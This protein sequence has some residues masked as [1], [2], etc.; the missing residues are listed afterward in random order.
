MSNSTFDFNVFI[1][2]SKDVLTNPKA[3]FSTMKTTGVLLNL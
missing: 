2:E 3:Y 1:K